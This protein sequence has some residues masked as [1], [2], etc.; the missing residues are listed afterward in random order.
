MDWE[1]MS[2]KV[3]KHVEECLPVAPAS[4]AAP[5][6]L[7]ISANT[8]HQDSWRGGSLFRYAAVHEMVFCTVQGRSY[9][10]K[11]VA[12]HLAESTCMHEMHCILTRSQER[13]H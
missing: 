8:S 12:P 4:P 5:D 2:V 11:L 9:S 10:Q 13:H 1:G 3:I 6:D 7:P